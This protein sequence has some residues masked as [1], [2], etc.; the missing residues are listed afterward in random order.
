VK[1]TFS[2]TVWREDRDSVVG[3][4]FAAVDR[5][6]QDVDTVQEARELVEK[7]L[8]TYS[9]LLQRTALADWDRQIEHLGHASVHVVVDGSAA[10]QVE[11]GVRVSLHP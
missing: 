9:P 5:E 10:W 8:H 7:Y 11:Y 4:R 3:G 6:V 1:L 2:N